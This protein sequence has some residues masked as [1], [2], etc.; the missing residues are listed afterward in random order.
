VKNRIIE[1]SVLETTSMKLTANVIQEANGHIGREIVEKLL[2]Q[3]K[4]VVLLFSR[5]RHVG[6][7]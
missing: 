6:E 2:D 1:E 4:S 3:S 5:R 7:P